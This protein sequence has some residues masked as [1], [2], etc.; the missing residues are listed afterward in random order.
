MKQVQKN[1]SKK[2]IG[3][4]VGLSV[5][6]LGAYAVIAALSFVPSA[7]ATNLVSDPNF[8]N[9]T[10]TGTT[11]TC[12]NGSGQLGYNTNAVGWTNTSVGGTLGY[13]FLFTNTTIATTSPGVLG[14]AGALYLSNVGTGPNSTYSMTGTGT[15]ANGNGFSGGGVPG[16][17]SFLALDGDYQTA[18]VQQTIT[19]LCGGCT[20]I[21]TFDWAAAQQKGC[22]QCTGNSNDSLS[23]TFGTT[24]STPV[25]ADHTGQ[26]SG[27]MKQTMTFTTGVGVTSQVLSFLAVGSQPVPPF[28]LLTN[29]DMEYTTPE[30][31][32]LGMLGCGLGFIGLARLRSKRQRKS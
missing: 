28:L 6:V 18:A 2:C 9:L 20:Y 26:F 8:T 27:W 13:N 11:T 10:C 32:T 15:N 25:F 12:T 29:I 21:L 19:G 7:Q 16:G 14:N 5:K 4:V 24:Q 1:S 22:A 23:V 30:P 17:G 3:R 31:G